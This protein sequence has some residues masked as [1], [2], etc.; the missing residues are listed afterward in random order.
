M[1]LKTVEVGGNV[2]IEA[3]GHRLIGTVVQ[4]GKDYILVSRG[5]TK[6]IVTEAHTDVR[7]PTEEEATEILREGIHKLGDCLPVVVP[8]SPDPLE[9]VCIEYTHGPESEGGKTLSAGDRVGVGWSVVGTEPLI[10][11]HEDGATLC[12]WVAEK[13][14]PVI[15]GGFPVRVTGVYPGEVNLSIVTPPA[16]NYSGASCNKGAMQSPTDKRYSVTVDKSRDQPPVVAETPAWEGDPSEP[17]LYTPGEAA[18][19]VRDHRRLAA[20]KSVADEGALDGSKAVRNIVA[21]IRDDTDAE[22]IDELKTIAAG[23]AQDD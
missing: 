3:K 20:L 1:D 16:G 8:K 23:E 18:S 17:W 22:I 19:V 6:R 14:L 21:Q 10:L 13:I 5:E 9:G 2:I 4:K 7:L 12:G 11:S 15:R